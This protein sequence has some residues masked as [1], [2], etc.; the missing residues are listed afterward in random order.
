MALDYSKLSDQELEA[1][2]NDNYSSLS[3]ATL[4]MLANESPAT[5][6]VNM[7]PQAAGAAIGAIQPASQV[8]KTVGGMALGSAKDIAKMGSI[9]YNNLTPGVVAEVAGSPIKYGKQFVKDYVAG[10]PWAGQAV[11]VTPAQAVATGGRFLGGAATNIGAGIAHPFSAFAMPYQAAAYE[12]EK[13][14]A[15][16]NAPG[17][18]TNPYAQMTRGEAATQGQAGAMNTRN[19]LINQQYGGLT[20]EQQQMLQQDRLRQQEIQNK[21]NKAQQVLQQPPTAQNF[22]ERMTALTTLYGDVNQ[23]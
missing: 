1:I 8:A 17:L 21:K 19:A 5:A 6:S 3:D 22:I 10:H 11:N 14:R 7:A 18:E 13:I 4:Q 23:G 15:N 16:P 9:L 12:Q 20:A 2:A